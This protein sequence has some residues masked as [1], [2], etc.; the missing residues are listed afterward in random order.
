MGGKGLSASPAG[1]ESVSSFDGGVNSERDKQE[2]D[3][4]GFE[5]RLDGG[6]V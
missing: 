2:I 4:S 5:D 1:K 3:D 6:A